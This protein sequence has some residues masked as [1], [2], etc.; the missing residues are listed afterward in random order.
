MAERCGA[1]LNYS[2]D[3]CRRPAQVFVLSGCVHE[4]LEQTWI[5]PAC[6][7]YFD[8]E[9]MYCSPC[10]DAGCHLCPSALIT[11]QPRESLDE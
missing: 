7:K 8:A 1:R 5:C 10:A 9:N 4:H 2:K 3:L 11:E 6:M